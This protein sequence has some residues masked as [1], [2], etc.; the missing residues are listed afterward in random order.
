[1]FHGSAEAYPLGADT[2]K[3]GSSPCR[4]RTLLQKS[5]TALRVFEGRCSAGA[6]LREAVELIRCGAAKF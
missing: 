2:N 6:V 5:R 3:V 4:P 1:M